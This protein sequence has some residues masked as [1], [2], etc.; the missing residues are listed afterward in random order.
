M[1]VQPHLG[2]PLG[3]SCPRWILKM[4]FNKEKQGGTISR[5]VPKS[6]NKLKCT[7]LLCVKKQ[8]K[9]IHRLTSPL[10]V[11][12]RLP[13]FS[14]ILFYFSESSRELCSQPSCVILHTSPH[15]SQAQEENFPRK[16]FN[17]TY[18]YVITTSSGFSA[19]NSWNNSYRPGAAPALSCF[20]RQISDFLDCA[21]SSGSLMRMWQITKLSACFCRKADMGKWVGAFFFCLFGQAAQI[22]DGVALRASAHWPDSGRLQTR[23]PANSYVAQQPPAYGYHSDSPSAH[24]PGLRL[25]YTYLDSRNISLQLLI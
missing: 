4:E 11:F 7:F 14:I 25:T 9:S 10:P 24:N 20:S 23:P 18:M 13:V 19:V 3:I 17:Y 5:H 8:S 22:R 2:R 16:V 15:C 12:P 1:L 21:R 6:W